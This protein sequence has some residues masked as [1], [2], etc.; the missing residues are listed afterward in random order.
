M[1]NLAIL[2]APDGRNS[3]HVENLSAKESVVL[4]MYHRGCVILTCQRLQGMHHLTTV[5]LNS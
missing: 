2:L 5:T 3:E 1:S 4:I